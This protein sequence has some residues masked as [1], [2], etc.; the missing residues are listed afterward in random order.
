M[1][2]YL[3][4]ITKKKPD[5]NAGF[6]REDLG[7]RL[8]KERD[9][10]KMR[11]WVTGETQDPAVFILEPTE[12]DFYTVGLTRNVAEHMVVENARS[13]GLQVPHQFIHR[14]YQDDGLL[15]ADENLYQILQQEPQ[16]EE[17]LLDPIWDIVRFTRG[18]PTYNA[19]FESE[20]QRP[21]KKLLT[22]LQNLAVMLAKQ[23][24]GL[25]WDG[26]DHKLIGPFT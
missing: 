18:N 21:S 16:V 6:L 3:Q 12:P 22:G 19:V 25:V 17:L 23:Y 15:M 7:I 9:N 20:T 24:E 2:T 10:D 4:L 13:E 8:G 5:Y 1:T 11:V 14:L 26:Q